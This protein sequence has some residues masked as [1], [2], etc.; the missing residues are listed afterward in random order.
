MNKAKKHR[1]IGWYL[2]FS[3]MLFLYAFAY[4]HAMHFKNERLSA[5]M[6]TTIPQDIRSRLKKHGLDKQFSVVEIKNGKL[7][8]YRN[9][10]RCEL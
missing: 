7:Y 2:L 8:F 3:W 9:G 5:N 1:P 4:Y 6:G 10:K